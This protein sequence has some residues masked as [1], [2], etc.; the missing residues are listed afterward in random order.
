MLDRFLRPANWHE[1]N[2]DKK[3]GASPGPALECLNAF[4]QPEGEMFAFLRPLSLGDVRKIDLHQLATQ[5]GRGYLQFL[6]DW[7]NRPE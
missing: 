7:Y 3:E 6:A 1:Q 2:P 4:Q 5:P